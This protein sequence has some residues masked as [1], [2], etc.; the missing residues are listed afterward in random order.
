MENV[1]NLT[2]TNSKYYDLRQSADNVK[3]PWNQKK[4]DGDWTRVVAD[5]QSI[6]EPLTVKTS[7]TRLTTDPS[8]PSVNQIIENGKATVQQIVRLGLRSK[9]WCRGKD[10]IKINQIVSKSSAE[11][12]QTVRLVFVCPLSERSTTN[13]P[14][15]LVYRSGGN[16][17]QLVEAF[18][19][20]SEK[21]RVKYASNY[22]FRDGKLIIGEE[23]DDV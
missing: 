14:S 1:M 16:A 15:V 2:R 21:E 13:K 7:D 11:Q 8:I 5:Y 6:F 20:Y 9:Q 18:V 10:A 17:K 12:S 23:S 19:C 4:S 22:S 3:S